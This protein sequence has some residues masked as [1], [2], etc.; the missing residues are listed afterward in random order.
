LF[1]NLAHHLFSIFLTS[2]PLQDLL[3]GCS[4]LLLST[5]GEQLPLPLPARVS[6]EFLLA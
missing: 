6:V 1:F 2:P 4:S 5:A 3:L